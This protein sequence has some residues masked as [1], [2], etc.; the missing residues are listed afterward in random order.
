MKYLDAYRDPRAARTLLEEIRRTT[1]GPWAVL[2]VCGGQAHNLLR[3]GADRDLPDGLELLHGPGCPVCAT[4]AEVVARASILAARPDVIV[5]TPGD[6][7]RVPGGPDRDSLHAARVRG[8]DVRVVYSPLDALALARKHPDREVVVLAVGFETTAPA[9]AAAVLEADRLG[10]ENL[11][12]LTAYFRLVPALGAILSSP[13]NRVR[14]VLAAGPV[15]AVTGYREYEPLAERFGVPI[16]VT[17]PEPLDLLDALVRAGRQLERGSHAVENQYAR[18]VRP[19]GH[20]Q[21]RATIGAVFEPSGAS[22]RGL[23]WLPDSG[24]SLRERFRRFDAFARFPERTSSRVDVTEC[25]D[26]EVLTGRLKPFDCPAFGTR[27][28]PEH[29][30]GA[31]MVSAEGTC[32]AYYRFR[33]L[34]GHSP[35]RADALTNLAAPVAPRGS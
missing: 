8:A 10:L 14:A 29:P 9:A 20:P 24:L 28:T 13:T 1:T 6:L 11:S 34:P 19:D 27:C 12:L 33:Q 26:G 17:G 18:A 16:V 2:E 22:W 25:L 5:G 31:A 15:C 4:P 30:L 23:G 7:L 3:F 21:S 32:A 35:A